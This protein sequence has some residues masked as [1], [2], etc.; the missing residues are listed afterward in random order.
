MSYLLLDG[1]SALSCDIPCFPQAR[2]SSL[3]FNVSA[4]SCPGVFFWRLGTV[5]QHPFTIIF[6]LP[7][8]T[9]PWPPIVFSIA[10][11]TVRRWGDDSVMGVSDV[12]WILQSSWTCPSRWATPPNSDSHPSPAQVTSTPMLVPL[13]RDPIGGVWSEWFASGGTPAW[14]LCSLCPYWAPTKC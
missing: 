11:L 3:V 9:S 10:F 6:L 8:K 2:T 12:Y 13:L 7:L 4:S 1:R 5:E 14:L